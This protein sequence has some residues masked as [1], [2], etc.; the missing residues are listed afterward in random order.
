MLKKY[1]K[2]IEQPQGT[3]PLR[4]HS[5]WMDNVQDQREGRRPLHYLPLGRARLHSSHSHS[6]PLNPSAPIPSK[7][8]GLQTE[9]K[10]CWRAMVNRTLSEARRSSLLRRRKQRALGSLAT[11]WWGVVAHQ[12]VE[13]SLT[14][15]SQ[16]LNF[17]AH[18]LLA[19]LSAPELAPVLRRHWSKTERQ[20][21]L[22]V[23]YKK[24]C[25]QWDFWNKFN[26]GFLTSSNH[27][28]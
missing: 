4:L 5:E 14:F 11:G 23:S 12:E 2:A 20:S 6:F 18:H 3:L 22:A 9:A 25:G 28:N 8:C 16:G 27:N 7:A 24:G 26:F 10:P 13:V 17:Q 1:G 21:Q 15:A 19:S